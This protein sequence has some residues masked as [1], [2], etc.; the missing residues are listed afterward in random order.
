MEE[1]SE[2]CNVIANF[3]NELL[4]ETCQSYSLFLQMSE[5]KVENISDDFIIDFLM[6]DPD[7]KLEHKDVKRRVKSSAATTNRINMLA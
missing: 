2:I 5:Q 7:N 1:S 6:T 4:Y 3:Y